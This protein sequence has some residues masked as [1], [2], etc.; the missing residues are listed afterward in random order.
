MLSC[1]VGVVRRSEATLHRRCSVIPAERVVPGDISYFDNSFLFGDLV[2]SARV[3]ERSPLLPCACQKPAEHLAHSTPPFLALTGVPGALLVG[4][5]WKVFLFDNLLQQSVSFSK[6]ACRWAL[7]LVQLC[8]CSK[9]RVAP[10]HC[11]F[12]DVWASRRLLAEVTCL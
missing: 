5:A 10:C 11:L 4:F 1:R 9:A 3:A 2:L 8:C 7:W 6:K 12:L